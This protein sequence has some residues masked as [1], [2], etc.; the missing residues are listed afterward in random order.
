MQSIS[1]RRT[2]DRNYKASGLRKIVKVI[3]LSPKNAKAGRIKR[4]GATPVD[5]HRMQEINLITRRKEPASSLKNIPNQGSQLY[6]KGRVNHIDTIVI[7]AQ[8]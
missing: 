8:G 3:T 1:H 2:Q 7:E 4:K 6:R 5:G